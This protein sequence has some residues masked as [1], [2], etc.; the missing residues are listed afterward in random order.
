MPLMDDQLAGRLA[1]FVEAGGVLLVTA[2]SAIRDRNNQVRPS[3]LPGPLA[4]LCGL[5][6]EEFGKIEPGELSL[7]TEAV[8]IPSGAGY[9]ILNP[10]SAEVLGKWDAP[11][12]GSPHAAT[13]QPACCVRRAGEGEVVY[14]GTYL[15]AENAP[16]VFDLL[17]ARCDIR[18][19][20]ECEPG[21][22]V[23]RRR[24]DRR[25]FIF[26]LNHHPTVQVVTHLPKGTDLVA[27]KPCQGRLELAPWE[28]AVIREEGT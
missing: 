21:V 8:R 4:A 28:V 27:Q 26:V 12:D 23:T 3:P 24:D 17:L 14:L 22:E 15:T 16:A 18:P 10:A 5:T 13:G 19:L 20:A 25:A 11:L 9:E 6:V 1:D 2:R 7:S